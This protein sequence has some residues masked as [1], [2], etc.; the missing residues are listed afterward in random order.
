MK[1]QIYAL[2]LAIIF[3]ITFCTDSPTEPIKN[4]TQEIVDANLSNL[5]EVKEADGID[6]GSIQTNFK[7]KIRAKDFNDSQILSNRTVKWDFDSDGE[8][9]TEWLK[10]DSVASKI[11]QLTG[12][13][14]ITAK[15][16]F[17]DNKTAICST[18]VYSQPSL[19]LM[20][21]D[22]SHFVHEMCFSFDEEKIFFVW[23][24]WPHNIYSMNNNGGNIENI[25]GNLEQNGCRHYVTA[26]PDGKY[27]TYSY[28]YNT[29]I[30]DL[31]SGLESILINKFYLGTN[32]FTD[33]GNYFM[34]NDS[35]FDKINFIDIKTGIKSF[36]IE[37]AR[38]ASNIPNENKIAYLV[39]DADY[40]S[41]PVYTNIE[42][43]LYDLSEDK[44]I[45]TYSDFPLVGEFQMIQGSKAVYF[46][47]LHLLYFLESGNR[48]KINP[49]E[50]EVFDHWPSAISKD[51]SSILLSTRP[52]L[53]KITLPSDLQ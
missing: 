51:G 36:S 12:K 11:F 7:F 14:Q 32:K 37:D 20:Q 43:I 30:L 49:K 40:K 34:A 22:S 19:N 13:Q 25:T 16:L 18:I 21:G 35:A 17:D 41:S 10:V 27:I 28:D 24:G 47:E 52:G 23:G 48:Y 15:I 44:I 46:T 31:E 5:F 50:Y 2:I 4:D 1:H 42:L 29:K 26:S 9:D 6:I 33:Y 3:S 8:F 53:I 39:F 38:Y 45:K